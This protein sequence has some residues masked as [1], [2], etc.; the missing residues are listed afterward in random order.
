MGLL[1]ALVV[2]LVWFAL[3]HGVINVNSEHV[4]TLSQLARRLPCRREDRPVHPSTCH[5]WRNPGIR[6]IKLECVRIGGI[7]HTSLQAYQRWVE[8][9]TAEVESPVIPSPTPTVTPQAD[10][11]PDEIER[12][13]QEIDPIARSENE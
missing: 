12:R 13:L 2:I 7:W 8:K 5:R 6:G 10:V 1:L 4:V 11:P 9:L 3:S